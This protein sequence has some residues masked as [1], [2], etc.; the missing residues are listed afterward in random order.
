MSAFPRPDWD[1][2]PNGDF[3]SYVERLS[4]G[5]RA[6]LPSRATTARAPAVPAAASPGEVRRKAQ[7][8]PTGAPPVVAAASRALT[9]RMLRTARAGLWVLMLLQAAVLFVMGW[10]SLALLAFFGFLLWLVSAAAS[11]L[12][13]GAHQKA[14]DA[15]SAA[16]LSSL[17]RALQQ[18][19]QQPSR[20]PRKK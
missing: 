9:L 4:Q 18:G 19:A 7:G 20:S 16:P 14:G 15:A 6:V 11:A 12:S 5:P 13:A 10:G 1:T 2:P 8:R 17:L 3:A